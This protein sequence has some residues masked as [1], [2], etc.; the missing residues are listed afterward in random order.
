MLLKIYLILHALS[1][2]V[3]GPFRK[4]YKLQSFKFRMRRDSRGDEGELVSACEPSMKPVYFG[5]QVPFDTMQRLHVPGEVTYRGEFP[6]GE[7]RIKPES[8]APKDYLPVP[9]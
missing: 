1:F 5:N 7:W 6:H 2:R 3:E 9:K 4:Y 8:R